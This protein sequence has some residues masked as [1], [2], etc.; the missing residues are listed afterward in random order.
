M[1][2]L[3]F[4]DT[5]LSG[6]VCRKYDK[7][8]VETASNQ[9]ACAEKCNTNKDCAGFTHTNTNNDHKC[10]LFK[11]V[12]NCRQFDTLKWNEWGEYTHVHWY[13]R[14]TDFYKKV[15]AVGP[16]PLETCRNEKSSIQTELDSITK[17]K[18]LLQSQFNFV[19]GEK[20]NL[21]E[22]VDELSKNNSTLTA[23]FE[24]M[25][26][27]NTFLQTEIQ[28]TKSEVDTLKKQNFTMETDFQRITG[29][30]SELSSEMKKMKKN[31]SKLQKN[32]TT[33]EKEKQILE[34][35]L[36]Y[37]ENQT[38]KDTLELN[39]LRTQNIDM[40]NE[41]FILK[42]QMKD[43]EGEL[44]VANDENLLCEDQN[45]KM[46]LGHEDLNKK[47]TDLLEIEQELESKVVSL[48][49]EKDAWEK[50]KIELNNN[51]DSLAQENVQLKETCSIKTL[52]PVKTIQDISDRLKTTNQI[53]INS[54]E[55]CDALLKEKLG[56]VKKYPEGPVH[57]SQ[58]LV[59]GPSAD[60]GYISVKY[61]HNGSTNVN[62]PVNY[63]KGHWHPTG[64]A[65]DHQG[66]FTFNVY[67][68]KA[69]NNLYSDD[70]GAPQK[71]CDN[72][73]SQCIFK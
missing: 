52:P 10:N 67:D 63:K 7:I 64:C 73:W 34:S 42:A 13:A 15:K 48:K 1:S 37:L 36:K 16:T 11:D 22:K 41:L 17:E 44:K 71:G 43:L 35:D 19:A 57:P 29:Q 21:Q 61:I 12:N 39:N 3:D 51:Y 6:T 32:L 4:Y 56:M 45:L 31:N 49:T 28:E 62:A 8:L 40:E 5:P 30:N 14:N 2:S 27:E 18:S 38:Q 47:V 26:S 23:D 68:Q 59:G 24:K 66:R 33:L 70:T 50:H 65:H 60:E 9:H 55:E 20:T 53:I 72:K 69:P 54:K 46:K 58:T 25:F